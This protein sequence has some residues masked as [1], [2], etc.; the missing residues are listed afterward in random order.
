MAQIQISCMCALWP[1]PWRYHFQSRS[2][3]TLEAWSILCEILS[4]SNKVTWQWGVMAQTQILG[5]CTLWP[6]P[7]R[8]W[9][10]SWQA[11]RVNGQQLCEILSRSNMAVRSYGPDTELRYVCTVTLT[12][13]VWLW[14]KVLMYPWDMDNNCVNFF[15]DR[16]WQWGVMAW[17][18]ILDMWMCA[19]WTWPWSYDL[20]WR[21]WHTLG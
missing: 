20:G 6:W 5:M 14:I 11:L 13:D 4:R 21:S 8:Y 17:T 19:L 18:G 2:W 9:V 3:H 10:N 7:W 1:W 12:L 16:T 15:P